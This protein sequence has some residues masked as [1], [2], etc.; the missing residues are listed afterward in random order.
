[1]QKVMI[2]M[3]IAMNQNNPVGVRA[4]RAYPKKIT[5]IEI[6]TTTIFF[7]KPFIIDINNPPARIPA[8]KDAMTTAKSDASPK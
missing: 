5:Y 7:L 2:T 4:T 8:C 1:M 3:L 6:A